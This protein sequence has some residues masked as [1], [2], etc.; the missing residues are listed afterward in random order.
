MTERMIEVLV[1]YPDN[2]I[3]TYVIDH[4][5]WEEAI[6]E[7]QDEKQPNFHIGK[8]IFIKKELVAVGTKECAFQFI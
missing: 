6:K 3:E 8:K 1:G 2:F 7:I 5:V 4:N